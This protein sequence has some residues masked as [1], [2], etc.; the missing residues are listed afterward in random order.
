VSY[1]AVRGY[2]SP[3]NKSRFA[4]TYSSDGVKLRAND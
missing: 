3:W 4:L 1:L 2:R